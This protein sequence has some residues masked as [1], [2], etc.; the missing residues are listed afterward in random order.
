MKAKPI[1]GKLMMAFLLVSIGVAIGREMVLR[2]IE[3]AP[4]PPVGENKVVLYYLHTWPCPDCTAV[5]A[6]AEK[7]VHEEFADEVRADRLEFHSLNYMDPAKPRN[8]EL[9]RKYN[10]GENVIIA[11]RLEDGREAQ[12]VRM[13]EVMNLVHDKEKLRQYLRDGIGEALRGLES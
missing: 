11:V 10:V 1:I 8:T 2:S 5:E 12:I 7:L 13:D 9:A 4:D 3:V 6:A